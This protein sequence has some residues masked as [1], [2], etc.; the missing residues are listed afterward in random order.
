M[1]DLTVPFPIRAGGSRKFVGSDLRMR[2]GDLVFN[3]ST[4]DLELVSGVYALAQSIELAVKLAAG[5]STFE[6]AQGLVER[7][8]Y[9]DYAEWI[10]ALHAVRYDPADV[11]FEFS[12]V[13]YPGAYVHRFRAA[14]FAGAY[15]CIPVLRENV[16]LVDSIDQRLV[17]ELR[18]YP[19]R[20]HQI[21]PRR[22]EELI[23]HLARNMGYE[24]TLTPYSKDGGVDIFALRRN[25]LSPVLTV[26]DCKRYAEQNHI[27]VGMIRALAGLRQQHKANVAMIA[28]TTRFTQEARNLQVEEWPFELALADFEV[29]Q[30]WLEEFGWNA[31]ASGLYLPA[32]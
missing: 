4:R 15:E 1:N 11:E 31:N 13:G 2:N 25:G 10:E 20:L 14:G 29:L 8:C 27:G 3:A 19:Q 9:G 16:L 17:E 5:E 12:A 28:T 22:F 6:M 18:R 21:H 32:T 30:E 7:V 23:A 26:I 24:V